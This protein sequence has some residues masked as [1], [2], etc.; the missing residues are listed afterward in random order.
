[1]AGD[2]GDRGAA[3]AVFG[4]RLGE[5]GDQPLALVVDDEL[6]RKPVPARRKAGKL[7]G[8]VMGRLDGGVGGIQCQGWAT[9][10]LE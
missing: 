2:V 1:V 4:N 9:I 3:V 6:P 5:P 7:G 8:V 10:A